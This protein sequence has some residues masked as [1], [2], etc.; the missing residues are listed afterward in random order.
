MHC[1]QLYRR[2]M[3]LPHAQRLCFIVVLGLISVV[4]GIQDG[5][6]VVAFGDVSVGR[7]APGALVFDAQRFVLRNAS[8]E[9]DLLATLELLQRQLSDALSRLEAIPQSVATLV[10]AVSETNATA[11][12]ALSAASAASESMRTVNTSLS[13]RLDS[14][15]ATVSTRV[16]MLSS[17]SITLN[18]SVAGLAGQVT[19]LNATTSSVAGAVNASLLSVFQAMLSFNASLWPRFTVLE[20]NVSQ[21]INMLEA[22]SSVRCP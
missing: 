11:V 3:T 8:R 10:K 22:M 4:H 5:E 18:A 6:G 19:V 15:N 14:L 9:L 16:D 7:G 1:T 20:N 2:T 13:H 12:A 21:R 17:Q